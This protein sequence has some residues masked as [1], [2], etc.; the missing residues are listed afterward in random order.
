M[1]GRE[2]LFETLRLTVREATNLPFGDYEGDVP[3]CFCAVTIPQYGEGPVKQ[4]VVKKRT[5]SPVWTESWTFTQV[6]RRQRI[7]LE[8]MR[9]TPSSTKLIAIAELDL[10]RLG[11][12]P[13]SLLLELYVAKATQDGELTWMRTS[14]TPKGQAVLCVELDP[15]YAIPTPREPLSEDDKME[16]LSIYTRCLEE[17][18][19]RIDTPFKFTKLLYALGADSETISQIPVSITERY[20][21]GCAA[22]FPDALDAMREIRRVMAVQEANTLQDETRSVW[23]VIGGNADQDGSITHGMLDGAG[24]SMFDFSLSTALSSNLGQDCLSFDEFQGFLFPKADRS[25]CSDLFRGLGRRPKALPSFVP[26]KLISTL[27]QAAVPDL[28]VRRRRVKAD[29][30]KDEEGRGARIA[31][32][33]KSSRRFASPQRARPTPEPSHYATRSKKVSKLPYSYSLFFSSTAEVSAPSP[34]V[35]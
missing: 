10:A 29:G 24:K 35:E 25:D 7:K 27:P 21:S 20:A 22:T 18:G 26:G 11:E 31:R 12:V 23:E 4:T 32:T 34:I 33:Q 16:V 3:D 9:H 15:T 8:V 30:A 6:R 1:P 28:E 19:D 14:E 13:V 2:F 17:C 5:V